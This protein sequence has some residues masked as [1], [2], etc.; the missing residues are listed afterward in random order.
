MT[1]AGAGEDIAKHKNGKSGRSAAS[2]ALIGLLVL[3]GVAGL[4]GLGLWQVQRL[5]WK[6][7]LIARVDARVHAAPVPAPGPAA[8][9]GISAAGDE[10]RRVALHGRFRHD[11]ETLVQAVT[12]LGS[13]YWVLTPLADDRGFTVLVNRGFVPPD[14]RDPASRAAGNPA[15][16]ASV[17]GLLR[18]TEPRGGFLRGNDPA[19][20]RWHSRDVAAIAAARHLGSGPIAPYFIDAD[21]A[22]NAGGY[23]VGGLTVVRFPNNHLQYAITWF[24]MALLLAGAGAVVARQEMRARRAA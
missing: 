2:L 17:T 18:I 20:D 15:G 6:E 12:D 23:P 19:A 13:G 24:V 5:A 14:R 7:A 22:P 1:A 3:L 21:A 16:P 4:A 10:Y 9:A 8:W 11:R